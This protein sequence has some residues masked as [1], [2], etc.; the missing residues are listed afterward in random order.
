VDNHLVSWSHPIIFL[1]CPPCCG[2]HGNGRCLATAHWTLS[3]YV[4]LETEHVNLFRWHLVHNSTLGPQWQ[5]R[6]QILKFLKFKMADG[7]HVGK[8]LNTITHL[9]ID[10]LGQNLACRI[11]SLSRHVRHNAVA[12]LPS[13]GAL[14]IQQLWASEGRTRESILMKF[15]T[16]QQIRTAMTVMWSNVKFFK[17][18]IGG[19][20]LLEN[21]RNAITRLTINRLGRNL[22]GRISSCS[23]YWKCYNSSYDGTDWDD[24]WVLASKQHFFCKTVS[25]VFGRY[26]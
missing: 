24:S 26:C 1:T 5:P 14:D 21:I 8:Y 9:A 12:P 18:Q 15:G 16:Q 4:R 10:R 6:Y 11:S 22:G 13:N 19:R 7:R 2:C 23:Q 20:S 17:I 3:S 25:L